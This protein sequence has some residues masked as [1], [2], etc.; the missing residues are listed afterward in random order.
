MVRYWPRVAETEQENQV[1]GNETAAIENAKLCQ[2][3]SG[4][5]YRVLRETTKTESV[6]ILGEGDA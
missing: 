6:L 4:K 5:P 2:G 1:M 3:I